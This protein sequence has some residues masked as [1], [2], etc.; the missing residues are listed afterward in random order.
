VGVEAL[1]SRNYISGTLV[2]EITRKHWEE[3]ETE[4]DLVTVKVKHS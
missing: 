2:W 1:K 4:L 3:V